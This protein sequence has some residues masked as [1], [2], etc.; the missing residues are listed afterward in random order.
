LKAVLSRAPRFENRD[1]RKFLRRYELQS[2][3]FG[4]RRTTDRYDREIE[5]GFP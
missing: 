5:H 3:L 1:F 4:K 2:L